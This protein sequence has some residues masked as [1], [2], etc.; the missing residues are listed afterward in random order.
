V[1]AGTQ[2]LTGVLEVKVSR[3][4]ADTT[5]GRV[6]EGDLIQIIVDRINLA[7]R[8]D[9]IGEGNRR[10][11]VDEGARVLAARPPHPALQFNADLPDDTHLWAALQNVSMSL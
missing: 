4:G 3:A 10:L 11:D 2:N 6:R 5:L 8:I 9:L 7:G 1:F